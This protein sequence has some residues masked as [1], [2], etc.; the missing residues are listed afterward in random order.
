MFHTNSARVWEFVN[1][2]AEFNSFTLRPKAIY[3]NCIYSLPINLNTFHEIAGCKTPAEAR[4]YVERVRI[5]CENPSNLEDWMLAQVGRELY[6]RLIRGYTTKQWGRSPRE[7]PASIVRRLPIRYTFNDNYFED[8]YQ[9]I[10]RGGY[11]TMVGQMLAGI[12][13]DLGVEFQKLDW[14]RYAKRL[15]YTGP[16]DEFFGYEYGRLDYRTLEFRTE[17][18]HGDHQGCAQVNYTDE[19]VPYTRVVEHKHFETTHLPHTIITR[20][21]PAEWT[22]GAV[23]YY[24]VNDDKNKAV[25]AKYRKLAGSDPRIVFGGRLGSYQYYNMDQV[26][27]AALAAADQVHS[28]E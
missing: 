11:T 26:I 20:E 21:Y 9:G 5:P 28:V 17:Q 18:M 13:V 3:Q 15:V 6:E 10:P 19:A 8:R 1:R 22:P 4:E 24:P 27:G 14:T 2:F 23:P 16:V 25:Y 12:Q 7:L